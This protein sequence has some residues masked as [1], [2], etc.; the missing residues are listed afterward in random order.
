[1]NDA[2]ARIGTDPRKS[3]RYAG[4]SSYQLILGGYPGLKTRSE[5]ITL[6]D[7][8]GRLLATVII[9]GQERELAAHVLAALSRFTRS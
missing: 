9:A 8:S 2:S 6:R 7:Q 1:L 4:L 3:R 5:A